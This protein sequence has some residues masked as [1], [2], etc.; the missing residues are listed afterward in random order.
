MHCLH[1][2]A[3]LRDR[4]RPLRRGGDGDTAATVRT[5]NDDG[6]SNT[7]YRPTRGPRSPRCRSLPR[8]RRAQWHWSRR[9][10]LRSTSVRT[11]LLAFPCAT[12]VDA[13]SDGQSLLFRRPTRSIY[14]MT[15][16]EIAKG[17][18]NRFV[19]SRTYIFLYL[20]M[21]CLSV[22]T[23]VLSLVNTGCPTLPFYI[24]E[25]IIN[26]AMILE[27]AIRFVAFGRVRGF[28]IRVLR[29]ILTL[30]CRRQQFWKSPF[31]ILDL[32][33]TAFCIITL[34]V[35]FFAG[36]SNTTKEEEV[37][38]TLLLVARNVLQ[39]GRLATVMR[40]Y[41]PSVSHY[42]ALFSDISSAL[43]QIRTVDLHPSKTNRPLCRIATTLHARYRHGGRRRRS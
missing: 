42:C 11:I 1:L 9:A 33:I 23:V 27:V 21:A 16:D 43:L 3:H 2:F 39:F 25:I 10:R 34:A 30:I 28:L 18:A 15:R 35:I 32:I 22:T 40:Q 24:L 17:I 29:H 36:C 26:G 8:R 38:D 4:F 37:L 13:F 12:H 20:G 31:N 5:T 7:L 14:S 19:H 6:P 41:V